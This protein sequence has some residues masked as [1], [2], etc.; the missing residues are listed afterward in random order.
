[1][2]IAPWGLDREHWRE[3][4]LLRMRLMVD[5]FGAGGWS[6]RRGIVL[7]LAVKCVVGGGEM[8]VG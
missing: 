2:T 5:V 8:D 4:G 1:M 3:T 7:G 6:L